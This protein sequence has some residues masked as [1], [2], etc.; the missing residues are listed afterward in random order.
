LS[1]SANKLKTKN[2]QMFGKLWRIEPLLH[3]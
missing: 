2:F 3:Q 1:V